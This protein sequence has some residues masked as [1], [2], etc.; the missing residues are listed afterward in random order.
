MPVR[1]ADSR[2]ARGLQSSDK[3]PQTASADAP[4]FGR[5]VRELS[6]HPVAGLPG[7]G[8]LICLLWEGI[9]VKRTSITM[10][11]IVALQLAGCGGGVSSVAADTTGNTPAGNAPAD[12]TPANTPANTP[13]ANNAAVTG[14][15]TPGAVSVVQAN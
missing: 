2:P 1:C 15:A 9:E 3:D 14:V 6:H 10:M 11:L 4:V 5:G 7:A 8:G 12:N 13:V